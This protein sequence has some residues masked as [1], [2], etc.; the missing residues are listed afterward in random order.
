MEKPKFLKLTA[1][2]EGELVEITLNTSNIHSYV[3]D[4]NNTNN[5]NETNC[6]I[7]ISPHKGAGCDFLWVVESKFYLD[8]IL[9]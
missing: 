3:E 7:S 4:T 1:D 9:T 6:R 8:S 2:N 5:G